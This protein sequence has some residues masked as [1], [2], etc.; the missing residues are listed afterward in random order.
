MITLTLAISYLLGTPSMHVPF[1]VELSYLHIMVL[2]VCVWPTKFIQGHLHDHECGT[3][4]LKL[5][6]VTVVTEEKDSSSPICV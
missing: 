4:S 3:I 2:C 5:G 6:D 1:Y